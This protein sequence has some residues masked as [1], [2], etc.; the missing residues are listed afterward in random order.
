MPVPEKETYRALMDG[1]TELYGD[2]NPFPV[3]RNEG[4]IAYVPV[5]T[6]AAYSANDAVGALVELTE[7]V[8]VAAKGIIITGISLIDTD[9]QDVEMNL[10]FFNAAPTGIA[11]NAAFAPTGADLR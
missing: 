9:K 5:I 4:H 6:T 7:V 11:D 10:V 2:D 8:E 1:N 3:G